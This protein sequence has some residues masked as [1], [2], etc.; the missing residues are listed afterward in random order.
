MNNSNDTFQWGTY[1]HNALDYICNSTTWM[2]IA[3]GSVRSGK[4]I[5]TLTRYIEFILTNPHTDYMI[6]GK[7]LGAV[8]RNVIQPMKAMLRSMGVTPVHNRKDN[9]LYFMGKVV[10]VY[11]MGKKDDEEKIQGSTFA[12]AFIDEGTVITEEAFKMILSR[13]SESG[14]KL[15]VTCNPSNP[16]HFLYQEYIMNKE[17]L[18]SDKL[19]KWTFTLEE[20]ENLTRD[21]IE[22]LKASY[23]VDS[24]FY[25]RY[26]LGQWVSG[27]G[28]IYD[29]FNQENIY[30]EQR[31]LEEYDYIEIGSDY[32]TS[33]TTC[34]E[35]IGV[36]EYDD[37][38]EFEVIREYG[39]NAEKEGVT[40]TDAERVEDIL[41]LQEEYGF[42]EDNVFYV[43]HDA[44][45]LMSALQKDERIHMTLRTFT[46]DTL[47][48]IQELSSLFYQNFL[49]VHIDCKETIQQIRGYE[50]DSKAAQRGE[51]KPVKQDDHYPDALRAPIMNHLFGSSWL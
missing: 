14:A 18:Q 22:N 8:N 48:C 30:K 34:Y 42:D 45:S 38:H 23:P 27:R 33:T 12:G 19:R 4:T 24:V 17:L 44:A 28:A 39:Y 26:I 20:N 16:N 51:D 2:N 29:K 5:T 31:P 3:V 36:L 13:L 1:S 35:I 10:A 47:E 15:F 41:M 40:Q 6:V 50:W 11:G 37:H 21:Y 32:G 25:K 9:E 7:T 49:K 46:P 43:S